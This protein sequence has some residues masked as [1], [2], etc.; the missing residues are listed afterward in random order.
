MMMMMMMMMKTTTMM[1]MF[2]III[3][4]ILNKTPRNAQTAELRAINK[5]SFR[6]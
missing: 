1:M 2:I 4:K 3:I 5:G 6:H